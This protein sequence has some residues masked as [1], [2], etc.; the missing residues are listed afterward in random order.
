MYVLVM[1]ES[2]TF[3]FISTFLFWFGRNRTHWFFPHVTT[4]LQLPFIFSFWSSQAMTEHDVLGTYLRSWK[5]QTNG[6][7][8]YGAVLE[9]A[10]HVLLGRPLFIEKRPFNLTKFATHHVKYV[11]KTVE[12]LW[13][14]KNPLFN[15]IKKL[16]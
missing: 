7:C 16:T 5:C 10:S 3:L 8:Q 4:Q 11:E 1:F 12:K 14:L 9:E 13:V 15:S 6:Q 2:I